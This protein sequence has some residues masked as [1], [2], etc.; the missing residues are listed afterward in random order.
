MRTHNA[1]RDCIDNG[2][3]S[4]PIRD[5][6]VSSGAPTVILC[7][8][9]TVYRPLVWMKHVVDAKSDADIIAIEENWK[10]R[11]GVASWAWK[12]VNVFT[13]GVLCEP[14]TRS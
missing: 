12:A 5:A 3:T 9:C 7:L 1:I 10:W 13:D 14:F 11:A 8:S 4:E 2:D 6:L